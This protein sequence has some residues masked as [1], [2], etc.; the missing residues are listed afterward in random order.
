M[1]GTGLGQDIGSHLYLG[2]GER[3]VSGRR[4]E[5]PGITNA[6]GEVSLEESWQDSYRSEP[7]ESEDW[8]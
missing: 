3:K 1:R 6:E 4:Q 8:G 7:E 2:A 5:M